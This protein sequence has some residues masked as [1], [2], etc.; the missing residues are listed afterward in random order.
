[1]PIKASAPVAD[2]STK[3]ILIYGPPKIGK[4]TLASQFPG[5]AFIATE[6]GLDSLSVTRWER[7]D[8]TYV[9]RDWEELLMATRE[10][11]SSADVRTIVVDIIDHCYHFCDKYVCDKNGVEFRLDGSLGYGKG[12]SIIDSKF[13]A[14]IKSLTSLG[15]GVI[16][17]SHAKAIEKENAPRIIVPSIPDRARPLVLG[18]VDMILFATTESVQENGQPVA[19]RVLKTRPH[20]GYEAGGRIDLG[21]DTLPLEY[22]AF[23]TAY[24]AAVAAKVGK[25]TK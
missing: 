16:F 3:T 2:L 13:R 20:P 11:A 5:S 7:E 21:T 18:E 24:D 17:L 12:S 6:R 22:A 8:G 14:Y 25:A 10:V 19:R 9:V 1:M 23:R 15:K 4:T